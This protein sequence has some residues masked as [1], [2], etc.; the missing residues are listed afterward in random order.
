V[1]RLPNKIVIAPAK[2][3]LGILSWKFEPSH[4]SML[5]VLDET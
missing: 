2:T 1:Q 5:I 4:R 3:H